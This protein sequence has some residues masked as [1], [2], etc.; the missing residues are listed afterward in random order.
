MDEGAWWAAVHGVAKSRTQLSDFTLSWYWLLCVLGSKPLLGNVS[1]PHSCLQLCD[2]VLAWDGEVELVCA[3]AEILPQRKRPTLLLFAPFC[4]LVA[5]TAALLFMSALVL[6]H[7]RVTQS[8]PTLCDPMDCSTPG[9]PVLHH[10]L[11]LA[12]THVHWVGDAIQP[13]PPL[14]FPFSA[15]AA[16]SRQSCPTPCD[17]IDGSLPGSCPWDSP[18]KNTGVGCHFLLQCMKVKSKSEVD[19][20]CPTL[21]KP[22]N[23]SPSLPAFNLSW[24]QGLF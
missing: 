7:V 11:E 10:L 19:Q 1:L 14:L 8:C 16:K 3:T 15:A 6:W 9:F 20:S 13:S 24:H 21:P 12:Q 18:S 2:W 5:R 23:C 22:I 4:S 17:S